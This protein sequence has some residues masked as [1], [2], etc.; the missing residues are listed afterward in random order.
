MNFFLLLNYVNKIIFFF[1]IGF[2]A[3]NTHLCPSNAQLLS[4]ESSVGS[5]GALMPQ[6]LDTSKETNE[7]TKKHQNHKHGQGYTWN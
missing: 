2:L 3:S 7:K 5:N 6:L 4:L 1:S